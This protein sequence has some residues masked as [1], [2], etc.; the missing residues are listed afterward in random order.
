[1][2]QQVL[3]TV[4]GTIVPL[5]T[6]DTHPP[7]AP[8]RD[9]HEMA[10]AFGADLIDYDIARRESGAMGRVMERVGGPNL[11]LA[12]ACFSRRH[13]Y[14]VIMTDGEQIGLFFAAMMK[15][16]GVGRRPRHL[17]IT[18]IISVK[19]K[20]VFLDW[21]RVHSHIDRFL[22]YATW[23]KRFIESRWQLPSERVI[24][25]PFMVDSA[26]F[27]P[28]V[29]PGRATA[30]P[31]LCSVGLERRDYPTLLQAVTGVNAH[32]VIAAASPWAKQPDTTA[33]Q[34]IPENV[35]VQ[36]FNQ[37]ELRQVYADSRFLVMPLYAVDFQAGVT[38]ILEA[39]AMGKAV[40]CSRTAGQ[41]D[42]VVDGVTGLYVPPGDPVALRAAIQ[43]LLD[44]PDV[45]ERMGTAGR[46]RV[47]DEMSLDRYTERLNTLLRAELTA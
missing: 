5:A 38:A 35:T 7:T 19:K 31:Q 3:L 20:M 27:A 14:R 41:T 24:F 8:R 15:F 25:T 39:M 29:V 30:R 26:F 47:L 28:G 1:M 34:V 22:V 21:L 36:K 10:R 6:S 2:S 33:G 37:F 17:M 16:V 12:W 11:L 32:A 44:H 43:R 4:S 45:A 23:Q 13:R 9:Y 40:I 18:H 42:V 46:Q